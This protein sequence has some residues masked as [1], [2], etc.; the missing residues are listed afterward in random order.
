MDACPAESEPVTSYT[1]ELEV[2]AEWFAPG[3]PESAL[4]G[5]LRRRVGEAAALDAP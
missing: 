3:R 2:P 5:E 1:G 4:A